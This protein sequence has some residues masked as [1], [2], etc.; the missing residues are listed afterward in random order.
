MAHK[1]DVEIK[2]DDGG[3]GYLTRDVRVERGRIVVTGDHMVLHHKN[4]SRE[5]VLVIEESG[6]RKVKL[7]DDGL[8]A[9]TSSP[10]VNATLTISVGLVDGDAET[11]KRLLEI[12]D[13]FSKAAA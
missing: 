12:Y 9:I 7:F 2:L 5:D 13:R 8:G 4:G 10:A 11:E 1:P 3:E 6:K